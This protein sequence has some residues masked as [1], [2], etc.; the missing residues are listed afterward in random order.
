MY[1]FQLT[2]KK[3]KSIIY[4]IILRYL[5]QD[6]QGFL[7]ASIFAL[8]HHCHQPRILQNSTSNHSPIYHH[9]YWIS[10]ICTGGESCHHYRIPT[11]PKPEMMRALSLWHKQEY[12]R[13]NQ[14]PDHQNYCM[15]MRESL[16]LAYY[17]KQLKINSIHHIHNLQSSLVFIV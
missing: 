3:S 1:T 17:N 9:Q 6:Q 5:F 13:S 10:N 8:E 11:F 14:A 7:L 16:D 12:P 4:L 15:E 2:Y